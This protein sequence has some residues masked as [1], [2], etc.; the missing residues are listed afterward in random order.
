MG[1]WKPYFFSEV[2]GVQVLF[3]PLEIRGAVDFLF[4]ALFVLVLCFADGWL[5]KRNKLHHT[6]TRSH[7]RLSALKAIHTATHFLIMLVVMSFNIWLFLCVVV[8][9]GL[10]EFVLLKHGS[11]WGCCC[12]NY[13]GNDV[14]EAN[15]H[16]I[17]LG[18]NMNK[19]EY[20]SV[21]PTVT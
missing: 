14:L 2:T 15:E 17:E 8:S 21:T 19:C 11:S 7:L 10:A 5:S 1:W 3:S 18:E 20:A 4:A 6:G 12:S 9:T 13:T 16:D